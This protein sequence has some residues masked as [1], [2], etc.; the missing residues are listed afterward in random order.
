MD[1]HSEKQRK[2]LEDV[3]FPKD[4]DSKNKNMN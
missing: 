1:E 4:Y 3:D 2:E